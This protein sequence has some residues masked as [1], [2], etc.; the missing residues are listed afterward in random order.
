MLGPEEQERIA[1]IVKTFHEIKSKDSKAKVPTL[2]VTRHR[3]VTQ[4]L[5]VRKWSKMGVP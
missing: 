2:H 5:E 3:V 1:A 4:I